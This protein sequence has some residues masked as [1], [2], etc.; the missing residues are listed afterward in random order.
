M[1]THTHIHI[2]THTDTHTDTHTHIHTHNYFDE[3]VVEGQDGLEN[4]AMHVLVAF[5]NGDQR[6][7]EVK[8]KILPGFCMQ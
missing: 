8:E 7:A 6:S 2:H 4:A 3:V 5:R 1:S